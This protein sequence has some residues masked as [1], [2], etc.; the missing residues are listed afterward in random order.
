MGF[1]GEAMVLENTDGTKRNDQQIEYK[2]QRMMHL[3]V[4]STARFGAYV[5]T[6]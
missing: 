6:A 5:I 3:G 4:L 1:E 2:F